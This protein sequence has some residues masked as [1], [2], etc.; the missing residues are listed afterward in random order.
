MF[1]NRPG[2]QSQFRS[3]LRVASSARSDF[4]QLGNW[5][6]AHPNADLSVAALADRMCMSPRHFA[7]LFDQEMGMP[8]AKFVEMSRLGSAS[9]YLEQTLMPLDSIA[10]QCGFGSAEIMR[11]A[12]K[13]HLKV[14][15]Q[16]YRSRFRSTG[17]HVNDDV[18]SHQNATGSPNADV[19]RFS[20]HCE[21]RENL[22]PEDFLNSMKLFTDLGETTIVTGG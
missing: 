6:S 1:P 20:K 11:R 8:P 15:P 22:G 10:E 3:F 7:R 9:F 14:S 12:Y 13:R 17:Q 18:G 2:G 16:E 4:R 19:S 5:I 21:N